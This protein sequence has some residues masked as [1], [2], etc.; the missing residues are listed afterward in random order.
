V[1]A[2]RRLPSPFTAVLVKSTE[3][4]IKLQERL[5]QSPTEFKAKP[6]SIIPLTVVCQGLRYLRPPV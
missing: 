6:K 1:C 3:D 2:T 5:T 4:A